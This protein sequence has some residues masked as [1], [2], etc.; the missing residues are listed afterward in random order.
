MDFRNVRN[1]FFSGLLSDDRKHF[2]NPL[3]KNN[4]F[5][6]PAGNAHHKKCDRP[7]TWFSRKGQAAHSPVHSLRPS[8]LRVSNY[9]LGRGKLDGG[10]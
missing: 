6:D 5:G 10:K 2:F 1:H 9:S 4:D 8:N 7:R 3:G